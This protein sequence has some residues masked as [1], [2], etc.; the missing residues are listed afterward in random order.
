[1]ANISLKRTL[2]N[3]LCIVFYQCS[4]YAQ[5]VLTE[6]NNKPIVGDKIERQAIEGLYCDTEGDNILWDFSNCVL[7]EETFPLYIASDSLGFRCKEN[8]LR[9][10][11]LRSKNHLLK[12]AYHSRQETMNYQNPP[13]VMSFP[14]CYGDS[15]SSSFWG[16]GVFCDSYKISHNGTKTIIADAKGSILLPGN[17][18][19]KE[20][21][22]VHTITSNN[23]L[24]EGMDTNLIDTATAKQELSE[25]YLWYA[26]GCRYPI[27]EY[28]IN[29]SYG[30]GKQVG[31]LSKAYCYLPDSIMD[32][33]V[34]YEKKTNPI[35]YKISQ[36][37]NSIIVS[38]STPTDA[39]V[40]FTIASITGI[41]YQSKSY[42]CKK[43]EEYN[44][45]FNCNGYPSNGYVMYINV[46]GII[47]SEKFQ[48]K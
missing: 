48:L 23:I 39:T 5:L 4:T 26:K 40:L 8:G 20:V 17:K 45:S 2:T 33:S 3:L 32:K 25:D 24:M 10:Y 29:K 41:V 43:G 14:F 28:H 30:N 46:N 44:V 36:T 42:T 6:A 19:I 16:E 13:I 27:L 38:Y 1:M 34:S 15:I 18:I 22:R 31:E 37:G 47:K 12:R 7:Q 11:Y 21:L 9:T 35:K